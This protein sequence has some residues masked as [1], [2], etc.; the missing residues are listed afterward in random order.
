MQPQT[1]QESAG[2]M[3][4]LIGGLNGRIAAIQRELQECERTCQRKVE[5]LDTR[6]RLLTYNLSRLE[7]LIQTLKTQQSASGPEGRLNK[8]PTRV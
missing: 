4:A 2:Q 7:S 5:D 6:F 3:A 1:R 8:I